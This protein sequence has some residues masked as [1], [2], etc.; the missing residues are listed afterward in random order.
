MFCLP[1]GE[2]PSMIRVNGHPST[3]FRSL[4]FFAKAIGMFFHIHDGHEP[5]SESIRD[6]WLPLFFPSFFSLFHSLVACW[7]ST[8]VSA[9]DGVALH[10]WE[11]FSQVGRA[12]LHELGQPHLCQEFGSRRTLCQEMYCSVPSF[13]SYAVLNAV[14]ETRGSDPSA[15][16]FS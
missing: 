1:M 12:E 9:H 10:D 14:D 7:P 6:Q 8:S 2:F 5:I 4:L 13:R 16:E 15:N 11:A 3:S